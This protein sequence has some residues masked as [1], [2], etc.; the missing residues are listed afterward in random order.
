MQEATPVLVE[1]VKLS[2][3]WVLF[4]RGKGVRDGFFLFAKGL[5]Y[6]KLPSE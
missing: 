6:P 2:Q 3:V 4:I 1:M 5:H